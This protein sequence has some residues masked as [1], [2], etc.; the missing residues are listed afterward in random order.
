MI[1]LQQPSFWREDH[2]KNAI[3]ARIKAFALQPLSLL[4]H[5]GYKLHHSLVSPQKFDDLYIIC[6]GNITA[7][8]AG[9]T[10]CVIMLADIFKDFNPV[11]L[12]KGYGGSSVRPRFV[13]L[14]D[15]ADEVGDE[16]LLMARRGFKVITARSRVQGLKFAKAQKYS[17]IIMDDGMQNPHIQPDY[18]I[19]VIDSGF[20]FGN[21]KLL[22]AGPLRAPLNSSVKDINCFISVG[23]KA[24]D[25]ENFSEK[26]FY[27]G[28]FIIDSLNMN[29]NIYA[30]AGL[31]RPEKFYESLR[32]SGMSISGTKDFPD[33]HSYSASDLQELEM[34]AQKLNAKLVT[35]EKDA[36]KIDSDHHDIT[37]IKGDLKLQNLPELVQDITFSLNK[38]LHP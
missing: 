17:L 2:Y 32:L 10:P 38:K 35:T 5:L 27:H 26:A 28:S 33:H 11:I 30:F 20:G 25:A 31:G 24:F 16:P 15:K 18:T 7:G 36:V 3:S 14:T 12:S 37:V 23:E 4:Y 13:Q 8:G 9:K 34:A 22:P 6:V 19:C 29:E 21:K 1:K